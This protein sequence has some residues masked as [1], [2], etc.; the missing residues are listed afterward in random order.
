MRY[1][2][3]VLMIILLPLRGWAGD[4][5]ATH[6]AISTIAIEKGAVKAPAAEVATPSA[7]PD[8]HQELANQSST[9]DTPSADP[10]STCAA[11]QACH[12]VALLLPR[13][14]V[15]IGCAAP[16]MQSVTAAIFSSA[17]VALGHK[18]PIF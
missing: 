11:C 13:P 15:A 6:M 16:H 5:M 9:A 14:N 1:F 17:D 2:V 7:A 3:F 8:C 12:T 4:V 18:P 10:C